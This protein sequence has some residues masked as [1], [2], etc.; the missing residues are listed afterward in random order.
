MEFLAV[1]PHDTPKR[2]YQCLAVISIGGNVGGRRGSFGSDTGSDN[3]LTRILSGG[4]RKST[5]GNRA[6]E[7][8]GTWYW[9]CRAG[10]TAVSLSLI[11]G[12]AAASS[13]EYQS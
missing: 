13:S 10:V 5:Q 11:G 2:S 7:G 4:R 1:P 3:G 6:A 8:E 12:V 9:R